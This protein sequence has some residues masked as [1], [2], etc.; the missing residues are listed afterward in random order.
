ME[1]LMPVLIELR[2]KM[3]RK[4]RQIKKDVDENKGKFLKTAR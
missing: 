2:E 4:M 3:N 1:D